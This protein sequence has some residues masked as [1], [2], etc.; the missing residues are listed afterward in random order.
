METEDT[1][2][3]RVLVV[4]AGTA[5]VDVYVWD[6]EA[7]Y[8]RCTTAV[9]RE[10]LETVVSRYEL[11]NAAFAFETLQ[12][13]I[14]PYCLFLEAEPALP[15]LNRTIPAYN[16]DAVL[17]ALQFN[18]NTQSRYVESSGTEV[19]VEN[20]RSLRLRTDGSLF[21]QSG[22]EDTLRIEAGEEASLQELVTA[23]GVLMEKLAVIPGGDAGLYLEQ[24]HQSGSSVILSYGY[25]VGGVPVRFFDGD[26]AAT[27][28]LSGTIVSELT[29]RFRQ[30][31]EAEET[32]LLLPLRQAAAIMGQY[33]E[34]EM[35]IG[36]AD[37]GS[38]EMSARWLAE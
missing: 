30:Y 14:A 22:G 18:P 12:G 23:S 3:A 27:I 9:L 1:A 5:G 21:Y 7:A 36:Y 33:Q 11:G 15:V 29:L 8:R 24:V 10:S 6:G 17:N 35:F 4:A 2:S 37:D 13:E 32:S 34:A 16:A 20:S 25:E 31:T 28:V 19:I 38:G 26:S